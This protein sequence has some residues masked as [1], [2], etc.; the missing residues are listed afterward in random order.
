LSAHFLKYQSAHYRAQL[1]SKMHRSRQT[2]ATVKNDR[3]ITYGELW[4]L[5]G[6]SFWTLMDRVSRA[7]VRLQVSPRSAALAYYALFST[8][9]L[10]ILILSVSA[11]L[12]IEGFLESTLRAIEG[13]MPENVAALIRRQLNDIEGSIN[14]TLTIGSCF[15]LMT[16][17]SRLFR[18]MGQGLDAAYGVENPRR[19]LRSR[20]ISML[21]VCVLFLLFLITMIALV[22]GPQLLR[23]ILRGLQIDWLN[24]PAY[25]I[26]RWG[27]AAL[28]MLISSAL[29]YW[30]VPSVKVR[31]FLVSPGSLFA[32]IG[33]ALAT[34]G[35]AYYVD[36]FHR[37]NEI[38]G[39]L[40]GIV[41]L[42][43]W[44]H[45]TGLLLLTGG[46]INGTIR[47][48]ILSRQE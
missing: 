25:H 27:T 11:L 3:Q 17:G 15:V 31:F 13:G 43:L 8:A 30:I 33:S 28:F 5:G 41:A 2:I 21:M 34:V 19:F 4:S 24:S 40:G 18:T 48:E 47:R 37:F 16:T 38:Y 9:P 14:V 10:F 39:T 45:L 44:F 46:L 20:L 1:F 35:I 32:T 6:L 26:S 22:F 23:F 36:S 7:F 29:L 12:P 42:L